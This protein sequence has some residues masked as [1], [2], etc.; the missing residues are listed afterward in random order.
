M[1]DNLL[2]TKKKKER[3]VGGTIISV[4]IHAVAIGAAVVTVTISSRPATFN[5]RS[6]TNVWPKASVRPVRLTVENPGSEPVTS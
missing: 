3:T 1:F 2:E 5:C 6:T 4:V